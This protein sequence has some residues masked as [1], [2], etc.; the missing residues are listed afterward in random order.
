MR[1]VAIIPARLGSSRYPGKPLCDI[2]GMPMVEHVYRRTEM[3][4]NVD[5][6]YVATP[7]QE[8]REEVESFGG[9]A[10]MTGQHER[11]LDRVAE[12]AR[13]TDAE[14]VVNMQGDEP[15]IEPSVI[16]AAIR[17][18][19]GNEDVE[20][21][22]P[23]SEYRDGETFRDPNNLKV[24]TDREGRALYFTRAAVPSL[25]DAS[26]DEVATYQQVCAITFRKD[27]L[28]EFAALDPTPLERAESI[29]I[30]RFLG[31]GHE[32][33]T[34]EVDSESHSVDTPADH[35]TV[36]DLMAEDDLFP[37]YAPEARGEPGEIGSEPERGS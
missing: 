16:D 24:V 12:A 8:I 26:F 18:F 9:E 34:V 11:A 29:D 7:D 36:N 3:A 35:R 33:H 22:N 27:A 5:A 31:S 20:C 1:A 17:P 19:L 6:A 13:H 32:V 10:V 14:V 37:A 15:L 4:D 25:Y 28:F 2:H 30:L 23:V 21:V